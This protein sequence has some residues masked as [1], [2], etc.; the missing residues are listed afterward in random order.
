MLTN[1]PGVHPKKSPVGE[2]DDGILCQ[3]CENVFG[4]WDDYAQKLITEENLKEAELR[5]AGHVVGYRLDNYDYKLLKLFFLSVAWR[6]SVSERPFYRRVHLGSH[7]RRILVMLKADDPGSVSDYG[8]SLAHFTDQYGG[9]ILDPHPERWDG[10]NYLRFYFGGLV[11]Y[12][13][14]DQ[15]GAHWLHKSLLMEPGKPLNIVGRTMANSKEFGI[16]KKIVRGNG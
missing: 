5:K 10:V 13:K 7:E 11:A 15:R 2:Y 4:P 9:V 16:I 1:A 3:E 6:A 14:V 8:V 12:V